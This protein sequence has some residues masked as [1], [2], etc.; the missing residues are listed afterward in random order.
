MQNEPITLYRAYNLAMAANCTPKLDQLLA[1]DF[2]L[3]H[4]T[5]LVQSKAEWLAQIRNG[6]MH[7]FN[8][9]EEQVQVVPTSDGWQVTGRNVV[10][11]EI[12]GGTRI[13]WPLETVM[14]LKRSA[15]QLRISQAVVTTYER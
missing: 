5:G 10:T 15:G 12:H 7:Y 14:Q 2:T 6:Q 3:T 13:A 1:A 8:S 4:M 11:A 9:D